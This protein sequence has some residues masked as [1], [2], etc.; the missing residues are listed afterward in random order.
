[1]KLS[2]GNHTDQEIPWI[3]HLDIVGV[4][5]VLSDERL[6]KSVHFRRLSVD[7][8]DVRRLKSANELRGLFVICVS[9]EGNVFDGAVQ[10][11]F[12]PA[13]RRYFFGFGEDE[14]EG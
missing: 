11:E 8:D 13:H 9:G 6:F 14:L 7:E 12:L 5:F 2:P 4:I 3:V 1:M 10:L